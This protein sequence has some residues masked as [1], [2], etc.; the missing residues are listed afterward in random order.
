MKTNNSFIINFYYED[1]KEDIE[2]GL[3]KVQA[4]FERVNKLIDQY[5]WSYNLDKLAE[6]LIN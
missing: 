2:A 5:C 1:K 4:N 6:E 3:K